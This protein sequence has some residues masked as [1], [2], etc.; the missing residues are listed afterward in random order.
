MSCK[1]RD[2]TAAPLAHPCYSRKSEVTESTVLCGHQP[3]FEPNTHPPCNFALCIKP[4][5]LVRAGGSHLLIV[6]SHITPSHLHIF[7]SSHLYILTSSHSHLLTS[8]HS[9]LSSC[10]LALFFFLLF[11]FSP[12]AR[13]SANETERNAAFSHETRLDRQKLK[14][15]CDLEVSATTISHETRFD[16]HKLK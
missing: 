4:G 16:R 1:T 12:K 14:S 2:V 5:A 7:S 9:L 15:N 13:E 8:S 6:T 3:R 11:H 10:S